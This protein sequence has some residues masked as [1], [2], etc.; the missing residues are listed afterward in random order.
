MGTQGVVAK[1]GGGVVFFHQ[2]HMLVSRRMEHHLRPPP[3]AAG[4]QL[5]QVF[6]VADQPH[7]WQCREIVRQALFDGVQVELALLEQHQP[8]GAEACH[9]SAQLAADAAAGAGD[10]HGVAGQRVAHAGLIQHHGLAAQQVVGFDVAQAFDAALAGAQ[11]VHRGHRQHRQAGAGSQFQRAPSLRRAGAGHGNDDV[12]GRAAHGRVGDGRQPAQHRHTADARA[13]LGGVVVQQTQHHPALFVNAGQQQSRRRT[14]AH[15]DGAA[16]FAVTAGDA[17]TRMLV[18]HPVADAHDAQPHQR[19]HRVQ[20][21]HGARHLHEA[22]RHDHQRG[23]RAGQCAGQRQPLHLAKARKTPH[24]LRH[25]RQCQRYQIGGDDTQH[26]PQVVA[27][28]CRRPALKPQAKQVGDVPAGGNH[29]CVGQLRQRLAVRAQAGQEQVQPVPG[30]ERAGHGF[31]VPGLRSP[32]RIQAPADS[33]R[34]AVRHN[35][36][37]SLRR[38][39]CS[40]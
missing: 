19:H 9:L 6:H 4:A 28:P 39:A 16:N 22:Q 10:E 26:H 5:G 20:A 38:L 21:Q 24:A 17:R 37:R 11:L 33:K 29:Q 34:R 14:R 25:A 27:G 3:G 36:A 35:T 7:Q 1:R 15:D 2:R 40:A 30:G 8:R 32:A 23:H 12:R 13:L 18:Q 31:A